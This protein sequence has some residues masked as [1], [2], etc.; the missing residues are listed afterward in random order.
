MDGW[1]LSRFNSDGVLPCWQLCQKPFSF[2]AV[3]FVS[4]SHF[5]FICS[6][7]HYKRY[8]KHTK[9]LYS[10]QPSCSD[11]ML[12]EDS[13]VCLIYF[14]VSCYGCLADT[15]FCKKSNANE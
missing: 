6:W 4:F 9:L 3:Y 8:H 11:G 7:P 10:D 5:T 12:C 2:L 15:G 1:Y 14:C 13:V